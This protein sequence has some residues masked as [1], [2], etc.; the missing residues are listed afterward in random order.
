VI[1]DERERLEGLEELRA[2]LRAKRVEPIQPKDQIGIDISVDWKAI[3]E[4]QGL[5]FHPDA[6]RLVLDSLAPRFEGPIRAVLRDQ[7]GNVRVVPMPEWLP[8]VKVPR[9]RE[10]DVVAPF[11]DF[12]IA[13]VTTDVL[14]FRWVEE[15]EPGK[16]LYVQVTERR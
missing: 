14:T 12:R 9:E 16:H 1:D 7:V 10:W 2:E 4:M 11:P 13:T 3:E 8:D 5:Q 6:F 15:L